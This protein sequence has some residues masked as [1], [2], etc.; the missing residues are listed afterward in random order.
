MSHGRKCWLVYSPRL[1]QVFASHNVT[2]DDSLFPLKESD[3]HVYGYYYNA[4]VTQMRTDAYCLGMN[5]SALVDILRMPLLAEPETSD[6]Y[7]NFDSF[8]DLEI[9]SC[10]APD[11]DTGEVHSA[12][13]KSTSKE[14][15][16]DGSVV[17]LRRVMNEDCGGVVE[18]HWGNT[19]ARWGKG[20]DHDNMQIPL[21]LHSKERK[22]SL[23]EISTATVSDCPSN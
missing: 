12:L 20:V 8:T 16:M 11:I 19:A 10:T 4:A 14:A 17:G 3:Q 18:D 13:S 22:R 9:S 5:D 6:I 7:C 23:A 1:N 21:Q 2:F 15:Q